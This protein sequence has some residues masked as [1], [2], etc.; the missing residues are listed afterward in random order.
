MEILAGTD[1]ALYFK[2]MIH[3]LAY[4]MLNYQ[5]T[6]CKTDYKRKMFTLKD[7]KLTINHWGKKNYACLSIT[8]NNNTNE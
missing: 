7:S 2:A 1:I 5:S 8:K 3:I 6:I 4:S